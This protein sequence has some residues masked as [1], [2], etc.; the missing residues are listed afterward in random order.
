VSERSFA[1]GYDA[2]M[3]DPGA[4]ALYG[5]TAFYNVGDWR[6]SPPDLGEAARRLVGMHLGADTPEEAK[7]VRVVLD[8]GCGLGAGAAMMADYYPGA[9]VTG[10]NISTVQAGWGARHWPRARFAVMDA[11]RLAIG[12]ACVDRIHSIEAAFHFDSRDAFLAQ[13]RRVL[14]PGGKLIL[15]DVTYRHG[16]ADWTP[17]A[18]IWTGEDEYR[19]RCGLAGFSVERLEDITDRTL[20]PFFAHITAHGYAAE[21]VIQ[22]RAQAAYYFVVLRK[23]GG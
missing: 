9:L 22:R 21:A 18:N 12:D 23:P 7:D 17:E 13:A 11:V 10:V 15:T 14:R 20:K 4:R 1:A 19:R 16:L 5:E 2:A 6:D 8:V 3:F